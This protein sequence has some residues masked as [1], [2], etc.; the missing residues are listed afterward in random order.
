MQVKRM[1]KMIKEIN[2]IIEYKTTQFLPRIQQE[3]EEMQKKGFDVE[4]QYGYSNDICT[5]LL[6]GRK[7]NE[8]RKTL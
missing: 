7:K 8:S 2:H 1:G 4:I 6:I 5:A 3:V